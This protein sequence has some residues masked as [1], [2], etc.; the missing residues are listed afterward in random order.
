MRAGSASSR[1]RPPYRASPYG[2]PRRAAVSASGLQTGRG[3]GAHVRATSSSPEAHM[4]R[5]PTATMLA[6]SLVLGAAAPAHGKD[7]AKPAIDPDAISALHKMGEFLRNQ[8]AFAVQSKMTTD[9]VIGSGQKVQVGAAVDLK[10]RRPDRL[11]MDIAGDRRNERVFYDG[12]TFT[13][14][15]ERDGYYA[16]F[17]APG[18][19]DALKDVLE[20]RYAF[21]MP[22]ADLFYWGTGEDRTSAILAAT[23]VGV[24]NVDGFACDHYAFHQKDVDW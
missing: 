22:L 18:T 6:A 4:K 12:K 20:K 3:G 19:L 1:A 11:R 2:C 5:H 14:Y 17:A 23:R 8:Q 13:V 7:P 10:V 21:D 9:D 15:S 16:S 24:A